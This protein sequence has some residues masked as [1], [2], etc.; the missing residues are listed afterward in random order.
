MRPGR[1]PAAVRPNAHRRA[2]D[3]AGAPGCTRVGALRRPGGAAALTR[4]ALHPRVTRNSP[5]S[6]IVSKPSPS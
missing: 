6:A 2:F 4:T 5:Y 1:A 3:R